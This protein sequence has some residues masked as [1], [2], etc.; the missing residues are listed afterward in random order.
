MSREWPVVCDGAG[1]RFRVRSAYCP[2][3]PAHTRVSPEEKR[4]GKME[5]VESMPKV[6]LVSE[7]PNKNMTLA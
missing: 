2:K 4:R 5:F 1:D 3:A 7:E 6:A